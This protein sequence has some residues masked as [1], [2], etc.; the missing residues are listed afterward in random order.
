GMGADQT[1]LI[2]KGQT[3][4]GGCNYFYASAIAICKQVGARN[5]ANWTAGYAQGSTRITL[6]NTT[7]IVVGTVLN[8]EQLEEAT[9]GYPATG[10][11]YICTTGGDACSFEGG[12]YG[13]GYDSRATT[14][15]VRVT[16]VVGGGQ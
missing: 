11:I 6:G 15:F 1:F 12:G 16:A 13:F 10:D 9:D 2:I 5:V 4:Q 3:Q 8:L 14:Q 7:G